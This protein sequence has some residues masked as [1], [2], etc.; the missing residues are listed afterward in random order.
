MNI[1]TVPL[2]SMK[3]Y[4]SRH[5]GPS[6]CDGD[7]KPGLPLMQW[8]A[9]GGF[10]QAPIQSLTV[11]EQCGGPGRTGQEKGALGR[12]RRMGGVRLPWSCHARMEEL[13]GALW[14]ISRELPAA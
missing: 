14:M 1:I 10:K 8:E 7:K 2:L 12:L 9:L 11:M 5:K 13:G 6:P 3:Q 4:L